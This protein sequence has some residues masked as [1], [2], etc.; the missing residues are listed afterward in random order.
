MGSGCC[1]SMT[2]AHSRRAG[3]Q[4]RWS[5][6]TRG[7]GPGRFASQKFFPALAVFPPRF[8]DREAKATIKLVAR[9]VTLLMLGCSLSPLPGVVL[10]TVETRVVKGVQAGTVCVTQV[11]RA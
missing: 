5:A 9:A 1:H 7:G 8:E 10:S 11:S 2:A 3:W 4:P 6:R